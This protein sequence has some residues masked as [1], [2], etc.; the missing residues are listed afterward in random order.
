L[1]TQDAFA[2]SAV[3]D[4]RGT[5]AGVRIPGVFLLSR[6]VRSLAIGG[7]AIASA[8]VLA[9][10]AIT[11]LPASATD[12]QP[13]AATVAAAAPAAAPSLAEVKS[14][15]IRQYGVYPLP[16]SVNQIG[17]YKLNRKMIVEIAAAKRLAKSGE[18]RKI[19]ACESGGDYRIAT[20]NGYYGAWQF[21]SGTWLAN[22]GGRYARTANKAPSW[23]QDHIMWK[24]HHDRGWSPWACA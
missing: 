13:V 2:I 15:T 8:G 19:R 1:H 17:K 22:G 5:W 9:S 11:Q 21:D 10:V 3:H 18:A 23:A 16:V 14:A 7:A 4:A 12:T 24:T 6:P 20:G